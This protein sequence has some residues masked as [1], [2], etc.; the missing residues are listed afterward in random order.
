MPRF[1]EFITFQTDRAD[2]SLFLE[3]RRQA[4]IAVKKA[5]PALVSV[6]VLSRSSDGTWTDVWI[7]ETE[8]AAQAANQDAGNISEFMA[9]AELLTDVNL[10]SGE[11]PDESVSPL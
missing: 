10:M 7:Y 9:M 8:E 1:A 3:R 11:I 6:P 2:D 4:I 5:H